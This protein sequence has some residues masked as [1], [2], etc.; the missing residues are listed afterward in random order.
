MIGSYASLSV[1]SSVSDWTKIAVQQLIYQE[2]FQVTIFLSCL[3]VQELW[4][5]GIPIT[6]WASRQSQVASFHPQSEVPFSKD[7]VIVLTEI[8]FFCAKPLSSKP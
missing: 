6:R 3:I 8:I 5:F 4:E 1:C 7:P 2:P